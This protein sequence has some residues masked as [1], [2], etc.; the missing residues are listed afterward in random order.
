MKSATGTQSRQP[1]SGGVGEREGLERQA[2]AVSAAGVGVRCS[3]FLPP[4]TT[5]TVSFVVFLTNLL[6][7]ACFV[8][9]HSS[10]KYNFVFYSLVTCYEW[11]A[12]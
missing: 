12:A 2:A 7:Y 4:R 5:T 8:W 9:L 3:L 10:H 6:S 1:F 11:E